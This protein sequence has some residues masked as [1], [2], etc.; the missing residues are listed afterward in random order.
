MPL[1]NVSQQVPVLLMRNMPHASAI[2]QTT[3]GMSGTPSGR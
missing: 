2:L 1:G 3:C